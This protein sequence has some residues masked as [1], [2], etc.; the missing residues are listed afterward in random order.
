[1]ASE[2]NYDD[3]SSH[4]AASL[5]GM[6]LSSNYDGIGEMTVPV[7]GEGVVILSEESNHTPRPEKSS[8][9]RSKARADQGGGCIT[10]MTVIP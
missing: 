2:R 7:N 4:V 6:S 10:M 1:M 5:L 3:A 8:R 9:S